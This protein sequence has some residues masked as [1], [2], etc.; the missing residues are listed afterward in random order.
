MPKR[1]WK[2]EWGAIS[3]WASTMTG[4]VAFVISIAAFVKSSVEEETVSIFVQ[5]KY[6]HDKEGIESDSTLTILNE[7]SNA[8]AVTNIGLIVERS[9]DMKKQDC[10]AG[11]TR[12][13]YAIEPFVLD[14]RHVTVKQLNI[15]YVGADRAEQIIPPV[16]IHVEAP[17]ISP[18]FVFVLCIQLQVLAANQGSHSYVIPSDVGRVEQGEI[19]EISSLREPFKPTVLFAKRYVRLF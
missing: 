8:I 1:F 11:G 7:G 16:L 19:T 13:P 9:Y 15:G 3:T 12:Y 17:G 18:S 5:S 4:I 2:R 14:A 10:K 6:A